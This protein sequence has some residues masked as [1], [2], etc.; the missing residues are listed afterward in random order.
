MPD[1]KAELKP[2]AIKLHALQIAETHLAE[3]YQFRFNSVKGLPEF[4]NRVKSEW[5]VIDDYTENSLKR[6]VL[7]ETGSYVKISDFRGILASSFSKKYDPFI[8]Y[9]TSLD[10]W[11]LS[12]YIRDLAETVTVRN[13]ELFRLYLRKWLIA[14][15]A[16]AITKE[17]CQNH[18]CITLTGGQGKF[19]TTWLDHLTP[20]KLREYMFTGKID[21]VSKDS[22]TLLAE[23]LIINIDDQLRQLNKKDENDLKELITKP[24]VK[25]RKPYGR[26]VEIYPRVASFVASVNGNDFLTDPSGSRRF[27]PFEVLQIDIEAAVKTDMD[28]VFSQ[29]YFLFRQGERYWFNDQ[30]IEELTRNNRYF[31]V[32]TDEEQLIIDYFDLPESYHESTHFLQPIDIKVYLETITRQKL[33]S[34]KIGE[35]MHKL[36]YEKRRKKIGGE[37][38]GEYRYGVIKKNQADVE[39]E[40]EKGQELDN[41]QPF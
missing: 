2:A 13:P 23:C 36:G 20:K 33:F 5:K 17:N 8:E 10:E 25:Y 41:K 18:T 34:K 6:E 4:K 3:R 19:K 15:V 24:F 40:Q 38:K 16:N 12:D 11:D 14:T 29:A 28:K 26:N 21:P 39:A 35:A 27:L 1:P 31:Q 30:E 37:E 32:M 22:Q 7:A 9:F